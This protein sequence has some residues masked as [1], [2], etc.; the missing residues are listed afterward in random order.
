MTEHEKKAIIDR[1]G[2]QELIEIKALAYDYI[3]ADSD[4][5][6]EKI[7]NMVIL[8]ENVTESN[9]KASNRMSEAVQARHLIY[10]LASEYADMY[11]SQI[12]NFF[13]QKRHS[14]IYARKRVFE[15][16]DYEIQ[17]KYEQYKNELIKK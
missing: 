9:L 12:A 10:A 15:L 16:Y 1:H 5:Y 2:K 14:V 4:G 3:L 6:F 17:L 7:K 11:Y 13:G 8:N